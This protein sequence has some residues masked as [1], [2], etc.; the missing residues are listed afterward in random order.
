MIELSRRARFRPRDHSTRIVESPYLRGPRE[1]EKRD[2]GSVFPPHAKS[3]A[4]GRFRRRPRHARLRRKTT[5][6]EI[7]VLPPARPL[8]SSRRL[9]CL[10]DRGTAMKAIGIVAALSALL[11][12]G[13]AFAQANYPDQPLRIVVGFVAGGPADVV[14]RMVGDK[15][16]E[17]W[18]KSVVIE[19]VTGSGGNMATERVAKSAPDGYTLLLGTS[20]PFVIH[21]SLYPKLPFDPVKDFAPITQLCFTAN[22]L[23]VNNDVPA[24][25]VA[26]LTALARAQ[27]GKLTF[28]SAGVGTTQHLSG[29][30]YKTMAGLDIQHVPYRGIAAVM[31]D[32][33]G[34]RLTMVFA[35]RRC[36]SR[37]KARCARSRSP[38]S[39][40][41]RHRP[42]CRPWWKRASRASTP[43]PGSGCW[44]RPARRSR[45]LPSS[46]ARRCAS[47]R[48]PMCASASTSSAWCR[49]A[50]RPRSSP[51]LWGR[52]LRSGPRSSGPQAPSWWIEA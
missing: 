24:K 37:A 25:S 17:A 49:W 7:S 32:L 47:W 31:P 16:A 51:P 44:R 50:P 15:L 12:A 41:R 43:L 29:E 30:M 9:I 35:N 4:A 42:T 46:I 39:R 3:R 34:G 28:G 33:L 23:V 13:N 27:P 14:A 8:R 10:N 52:R 2:E 36:R 21:P 11:T 19:N 20:G 5:R 18:G 22:V 26:D 38:R 40:A 48:C 1:D 6:P 45:S